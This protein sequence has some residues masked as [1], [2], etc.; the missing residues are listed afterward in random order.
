MLAVP[1]SL[2][3]LVQLTAVLAFS[4]TLSAGQAPGSTAPTSPQSPAGD[5]QSAPCAHLADIA[6]PIN[7]TV[8][9]K[10]DGMDSAHLKPGKEIWFKVAH[11]VIYPKCTLEAD[12]VVYAHIMSVN[13]TKNPDSSEL[14][15]AFDRA[16][17]NSHDKQPFKLRVI[18][19]VGPPDQAKRLH[20]ATPTQVKGAGRQID[21]AVAGTNALDLDLNPGG[22]ANTVHPGI[23]AG[24]PNLKLEPTGGPE[25]SDKLTSTRNRI[26]LGPGSEL[27][28]ALTETR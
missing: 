18:A 16:D 21:N 19:V 7:T 8:E 24:V 28:L 20:D 14:S 12:S 6:V 17:C 10:V 5:A 27:I 26:Q 25:C 15:L 23:V 22:P 13:S 1:G 9:A 2:F 4:A 3:R 11:G